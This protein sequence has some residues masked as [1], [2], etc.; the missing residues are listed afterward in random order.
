MS[1]DLSLVYPATGQQVRVVGTPDAPEW[2]ASDVCAILGIK[3]PADTV[4]KT[5]PEEERGV[6]TIHT[7]GGAQ[8]MLTLKEPGLYRFI[9]RSNKAGAEAF[10]RWVFHDVL[11]SIR[12]HGAYVAPGAAAGPTG[13]KALLAMVQQLVDL[14]AAAAEQHRKLEELGTRTARIEARA[15]A[16]EADLRGLPP[17]P[18]PAPA[19][20]WRA[21]LNE[22]VRSWAIQHDGAYQEAWRTLRKEL[23]YRA[24]FDAEARARHSNR[25]WLDEVELAGL[26]PTLYAIACEVLTAAPHP[27]RRVEAVSTATVA[28]PPVDAVIDLRRPS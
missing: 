1:L 2:V 14:E 13:A 8:P 3:R 27:A 11:P 16:A 28:F 22:R 26:M 18:V 7:P 6:G 20:S 25:H 4:A 19:K 10:R 21:V 24:S 12:Q 17:A 5:I 9:F 15:T 23:R